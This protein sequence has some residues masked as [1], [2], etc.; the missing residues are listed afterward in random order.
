MAP[1]PAGLYKQTNRPRAGLNQMSNSKNSSFRYVILAEFV[2]A[3]G[4]AQA[5]EVLD[6]YNPLPALSLVAEDIWAKNAMPEM[7]EA[8]YSPWTGRIIVHAGNCAEHYEIDHEYRQIRYYQPAARYGSDSREKFIARWASPHT[9]YAEK[10]ERKVRYAIQQNA[11]LAWKNEI[12]GIDN[13]EGSIIR[14]FD[15]SQLSI[16]KISA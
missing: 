3:Y 2:R 11:L 15:G 13:I 8:S 12:G 16:A 4:L 1:K 7:R 14:F 5:I 6:D 10:A 9:S